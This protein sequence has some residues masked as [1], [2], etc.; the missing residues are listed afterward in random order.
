VVRACLSKGARP[1]SPASSAA[2]SPALWP[3]TP[4]TTRYMPRSASI[5][6]ASSLFRRTRPMSLAPAALARALTIGFAAAEL[7]VHDA[8]QADPRLRRHRRF[9]VAVALSPLRELD[10]R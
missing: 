7:Q 5:C 3:P 10:A 6:H 1:R 8:R 4:S 9:Y 2:F